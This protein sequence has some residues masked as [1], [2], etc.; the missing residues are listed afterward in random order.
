[1]KK[2]SALVFTG[3]IKTWFQNCKNILLSESCIVKNFEDK[4][5][6][7]FDVEI[8]KKE[9]NEDIIKDSKIC[10]FYYNRLLN[11]AI[12]NLKD[13]YQV[14]WNKKSWELFLG[15]W[16]HRYISTIENR[17]NLLSHALKKYKIDKIKIATDREFNLLSQDQAQF[18]LITQSDEWNLKLFTKLYLRY[19]QN[20]KIQVYKVKI[21]GE[22]HNL[23]NSSSKELNFKSSIYRKIL[24]YFLKFFGDFTKIVFYRTYFGSK[25]FIILLSLIN[26]NI[27]FIYDFNL[28]IPETNFIHQK[29]K[30]KFHTRYKVNK[31]EK[32]LRELFFEFLP[33]FYL[34]KFNFIKNCSK[35]LILPS[36]R[37]RKIYTAGGLWYDD[38]FKFWLSNSISNQSKLFYFQHGCNYGTTKY[39]YAEDLE[40]KLSNNFYTWGWKSK[41]KKTKRFFSNKLIG[42]KKFYPIKSKEILVVGT[43]PLIYK[44]GLTSGIMHGRKSRIYINSTIHLLRDLSSQAK[45]QISFRPFPMHNYNKEIEILNLQKYVE[46]SFSKIKINNPKINFI[47]ILDEFKLVIHT[48]DGTSFLETMALNKPSVLIMP[49]ECFHHRKSVDYFYKRLKDAKILHTNKNSLLKFLNNIDINQWWEKDHTQSIKDEFSKE[50][51]YYVTNPIKEFNKKLN[52]RNY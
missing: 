30:T 51:C 14:D 42:K 20:K 13:I 25:K 12:L 34:E 24:R 49:K 41:G 11:D 22:K 3:I 44:S 8:S 31:F 45:Y 26:K 39:S 5:Y 40:I 15:P 36:T 17:Y 21:R 7:S 50:F 27:P 23:I 29:R 52:I 33:F 9:V 16:I 10:N 37:K 4:K 32:I 35:K 2:K 47:K 6:K 19:F 38:I 48:L 18:R 43:C 1:M 28:K 46:K